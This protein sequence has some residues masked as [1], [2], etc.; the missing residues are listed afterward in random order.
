MNIQAAL[1][2]LGVRDDTLSADEK[3][4]LDEEGY[5]PLPG[6]LMPAQVQ[7][8][9]T[10]LQELEEEEGEEAGKEVHQ[11][12]GTARLA[13]LVNKG[14][15]FDLCWTNQKVLAAM[16][17]V[18]GGDLKLSS[19]NARASLPG[20]GLQALHC[21]GPVRPQGA[22]PNDSDGNQRFFGCNSI[23]LL[24]DFTPENGATRLV[25]GSHK[26]GLNPREDFED[27]MAPHADEILVQGKA[28]TVFV[29]NAL[30]WHGG[31]VNRT[32]R[33]RRALHCYFTRR[34]EPQQTDQ[35]FY[36]R[37]ETAARLG[38]AQKTVLDV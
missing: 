28:G 29:F 1:I 2:A 14:P 6:I 9:R 34:G 4:T 24:S 3:R 21:D 26:S 32:D 25:P 33:P 38:E 13:N 36:L 16:S 37:P 15:I 19:L 18:L 12:A 22:A 23:W 31:T 5:L 30:T 17:H 20:Q 7:A 11:E 10:R 8:L 35:R 27:P